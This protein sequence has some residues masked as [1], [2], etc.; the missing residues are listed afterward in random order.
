MNPKNRS[1]KY[2]DL[3]LSEMRLFGEHQGKDVDEGFEKSW[4]DKAVGHSKDA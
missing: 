1:C 4:S 3:K 2:Q